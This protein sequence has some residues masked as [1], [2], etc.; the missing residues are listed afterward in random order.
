MLASLLGKQVCFISPAQIFLPGVLTR[1]PRDNKGCFISVAVWHHQDPSGWENWTVSL[2]AVPERPSS[3][4]CQAARRP[5]SAVYR[6]DC[7]ERTGY[8]MRSFCLPLV[9]VSLG[10]VS[11][12]CSW[13]LKWCRF[14]AFVNSKLYGQNVC[15]PFESSKFLPEVFISF[16]K[17]SMRS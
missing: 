8:Q 16:H 9:P 10:F 13:Q 2:S 17:G 14:S 11:G 3:G 12:V 15:A 6:P 4:S 1:T 5:F 7:V